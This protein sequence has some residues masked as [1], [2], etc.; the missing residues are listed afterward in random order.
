MVLSVEAATLLDNGPKYA[1]AV[2][3]IGAVGGVVLV[4]AAFV[5]SE[6]RR[7]GRPSCPRAGSK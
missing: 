7:R 4:L 2:V 6:H 5:L 1:R 3:E